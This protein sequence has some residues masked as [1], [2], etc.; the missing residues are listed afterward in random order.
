MVLCSTFFLRTEF[1][2]N[3]VEGLFH[4]KCGTGLSKVFG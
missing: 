2:M 4:R 1:K 3:D